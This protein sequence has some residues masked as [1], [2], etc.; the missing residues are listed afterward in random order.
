MATYNSLAEASKQSNVHVSCINSC[1]RGI[2][3]TAG[4]YRWQYANDMMAQIPK[5]VL[6]PSKDALI[7]LLEDTSCNLSEIARRYDV[8]GHAV[9]KWLKKY[10]LPYR[11]KE[12]LLYIDSIDVQAVS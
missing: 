6:M 5:R 1:V 12:L 8:T 2:T 11:K 9:T 7:K 10:G 3:K 4:G